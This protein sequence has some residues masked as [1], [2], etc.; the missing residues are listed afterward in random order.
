MNRKVSD[1]ASIAEI[2]GTIAV[3]ASLVFVIRGI[4]QNTKAIEAAEANNIWQAWRET[5]QLPVINDANF[6]LVRAKAQNSE[7][8]SDVEQVQWNA[9]MAAQFDIWA[10]LFDLRSSDLIS[11]ELW[12]YWDD[13]FIKA[14][15]AGHE[16]V[17]PKIKNAYSSEFR[18]H[19]ESAAVGQSQRQETTK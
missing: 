15:G 5:V 18:A 6:A 19:V 12:R 1:W 14:W 10:Q 9:Y 2:V 11:Q 17:W 13:G 8:L 4:D 16:G 7:T 3:V